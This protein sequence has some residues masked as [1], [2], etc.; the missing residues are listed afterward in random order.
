M[1]PT[2]LFPTLLVLLFLPGC[3]MSRPD[4]G[5]AYSKVT[6]WSGPLSPAAQSPV[7][8]VPTAT[9]PSTQAANAVCFVEAPRLPGDFRAKRV[10]KRPAR[11]MNPDGTWSEIRT[12]E[13]VA[14][15]VTGESVE[16]AT[17]RVPV[18]HPGGHAPMTIPAEWVDVPGEP[19]PGLAWIPAVCEGTIDRSLTLS[20][21]RGLRTLGYFNDVED[22]IYGPMTMSAVERFKRDRLLYGDGLTFETLDALAIPRPEPP[23][24]SRH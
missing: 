17:V 8:T 6:G 2:R 4:G 21:Q 15:R 1:R 9:A 19:G 10:L 23:A 7:S 13:T 14:L 12:D 22:G 16:S 24:V 18:P 3:L 20:V 5:T 11:T